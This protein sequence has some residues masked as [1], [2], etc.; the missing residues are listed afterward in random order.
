M[1]LEELGHVNLEI[2][3][4]MLNGTDFPLRQVVG[5]SQDEQIRLRRQVAMWS[6]RKRQTWPVVAKTCL[7][8]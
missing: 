6:D 3:T 7:C 2:M 1:N 4:A 5:D 8:C